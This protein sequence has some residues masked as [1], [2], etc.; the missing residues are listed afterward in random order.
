MT[1]VLRLPDF[2]NVAAGLTATLKIPRWQLTLTRLVLVLGGTFTKA[3]I[4]SI[5]LKIGT[6]V[7]W[8]ST[9]ADQDAINK[10]LGIFDKATHLPISFEERDFMN[11]VA[12]EIGGYDMSVLND[13]L[14][15]EVKI[16]AGAVNPTLYANG[17]F[18]PPQTKSDDPTQLVQKLV[19]INVPLTYGGAGNKVQVQFDPRGAL[20]KRAY[21]FYSGTDWTASANGNISKVDVRVNGYSK[22]EASCLDARFDQQCYRRVPQSKLF[23]ADF[24]FD[25]KL[26][27]ALPTEGIASIE[28]NVFPGATDVCRAYFE[29][30]D[31]PFNL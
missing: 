1:T 2:S 31:K 30:L 14:Y 28:W 22:F 24:T 25:N 13:D 17:Y 4:E 5:V 6:R 12:R 9:G 7:V 20:V 15:L 3:Q 29:V 18:T 21:L 16:A 19:N 27:G 23:V 26:E 11:I 8:S 10:Y